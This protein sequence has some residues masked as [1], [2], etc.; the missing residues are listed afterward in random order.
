MFETF[1]VPGM[2]IATQA[3]LCLYANELSR[4]E[5]GAVVFERSVYY[6]MNSAVSGVV[7]DAGEGGT[8]IIPVVF[9]V[10]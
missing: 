5:G 6:Q 3:V 9:A 10:V 4:K 1:N 2:Y 7:V 8:S